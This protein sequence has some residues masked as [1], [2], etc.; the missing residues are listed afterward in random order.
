MIGNR[1]LRAINFAPE[2]SQGSLGSQEIKS[3]LEEKFPEY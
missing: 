3:N 1:I 2:H